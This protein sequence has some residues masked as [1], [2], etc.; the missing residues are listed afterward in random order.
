MTQQ[1]KSVALRV[2]LFAVGV[3]IGMLLFLACSMALGVFGFPPG[4]ALYNGYFL[5]IAVWAVIAIVAYLQTKN[6][7]PESRWNLAAFLAGIAAFLL[8]G[9]IGVLVTTP[10]FLIF[11]PN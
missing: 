9:A 6:W 3:G 4:Y 10:Q 2:V 5:G 7:A 1:L 11:W 8:V